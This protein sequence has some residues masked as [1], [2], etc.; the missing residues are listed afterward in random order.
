MTPFETVIQKMLK[1]HAAKN[2][3]YTC[4]SP[5]ELKNFRTVEMFGIKMVDGIFARMTDKF[6]R[7][8]S[9]WKKAKEGKEAEV[10]DE[11]ITD[12]LLDLAN[13]AVIAITALEEL[14]EGKGLTL[15]DSL[16]IQMEEGEDYDC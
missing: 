2:S 6:C 12:T 13:Y 14:K 9:L 4:D 7:I 16:G 10:K 8:A 3:D 11:A 5:D 1:I 15:P